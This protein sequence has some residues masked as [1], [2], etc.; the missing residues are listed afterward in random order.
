MAFPGRR[1]PWIPNKPFPRPVKHPG[2]PKSMTIALGVLAWDGIVV[3]ADR[4]LGTDYLKTDQGKIISWSHGVA[5]EFISGI[6]ISGAGMDGYL[7][8]I[9][10]QM[11]DAAI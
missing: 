7:H 3:A 10:N 2:Y 11:M 4:E 5:G 9:R 6:V 1:L 8:H